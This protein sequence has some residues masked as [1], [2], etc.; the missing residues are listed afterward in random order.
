MIKEF[1]LERYRFYIN[2]DARMVVA[3]ST[4]AGKP[5]R[6][7]AKCADKDTWDVEFGKKLAA[8]RC[9]L[10]IAR[11]RVK[12]AKEITEFGRSLSNQVLEQY[13][14]DRTYWAEALEVYDRATIHLND[15]LNE[16]K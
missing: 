10:K 6:G 11:E 14:N 1:P 4:F 7:I 16:D 12:Y 15:L 13:L 5:F 8:A 9:G 2:E 3:V